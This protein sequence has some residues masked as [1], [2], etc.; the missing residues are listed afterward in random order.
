MV[1]VAQTLS[2]AS[3]AEAGLAF[4]SGTSRT[5]QF[6]VWNKS[7]EPFAKA[8]EEKKFAKTLFFF[9]LSRRR[10][11]DRRPGTPVSDRL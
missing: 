8:L 7:A 2:E 6:K 3:A 5:P 11:E 4:P 10:A 1:V 9:F